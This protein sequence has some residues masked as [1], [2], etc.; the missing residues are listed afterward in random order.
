MSDGRIVLLDNALLCRV[1]R[2]VGYHSADDPPEACSA[3]GLAA[4]NTWLNAI[5]F[6]DRIVLL[7]N[8]DVP[9]SAWMSDSPVSDAFVE[10]GCDLHRARSEALYP[11]LFEFLDTVHGVAT[12]TVT[13][14]IS[15]YDTREAI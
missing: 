2:L 11:G 12:S 7:E 8:P 14:L 9:P 3:E 10:I 6:Y 5:V 4:L 1:A 13:G 15:R